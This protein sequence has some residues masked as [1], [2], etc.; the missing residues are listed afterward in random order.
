MWSK[1]DSG[2]YEKIDN[3]IILYIINPLL[4]QELIECLIYKHAQWNL[5]SLYF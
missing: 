3:Y 1:H 4:I 2:V 5:T